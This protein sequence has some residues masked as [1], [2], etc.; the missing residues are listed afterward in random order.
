MTEV[1][2]QDLVHIRQLEQ[3]L[4]DTLCNPV[5][6]MTSVEERPGVLRRYWS[7]FLDLHASQQPGQRPLN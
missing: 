4:L 5:G 6:G 1:R 3:D 7:C 2:S